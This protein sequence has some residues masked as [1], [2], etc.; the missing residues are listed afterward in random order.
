MVGIAIGLQALVARAPAMQR[1]QDHRQVIG[2]AER[3][4]PAP[5]SRPGEGPLESLLRRGVLMRSDGARRRRSHELLQ[6]ASSVAIASAVA[7]K[8]SFGESMSIRAV[9]KRAR[10]SSFSTDIAAQSDCSY[11]N[12]G[13]SLPDRHQGEVGHETVHRS[14]G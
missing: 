10:V 6:C 7:W 14:G 3:E 1:D 5:L 13:V 11:E 12:Q 9:K 2:K 4:L 8:A